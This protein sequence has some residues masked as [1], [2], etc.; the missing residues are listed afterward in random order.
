[1]RLLVLHKANL[2][3]TP[4]WSLRG[5]GWRWAFFGGACEEVTFLASWDSLNSMY[6]NLLDI[7]QMLATLL[8]DSLMI[9]LIAVPTTLLPRQSF[10]AFGHTFI[11]LNSF[12][13]ENFYAFMCLCCWLSRLNAFDNAYP[14]FLYMVMDAFT[15]FIKVYFFTLIAPII[16][17][18]KMSHSNSFLSPCAL[19]NFYLI[20]G[21]DFLFCF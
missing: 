10:E 12:I 21:L 16:L 8:T 6:K 4:R 11:R 13:F 20:L 17:F 18:L 1:M 19:W 7:P 5:A 14:F 9:W 3:W 2:E 15:C